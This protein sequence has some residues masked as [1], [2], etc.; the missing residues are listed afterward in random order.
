MQLQAPGRVQAAIRP[1]G[2]RR[3]LVV[4]QAERSVRE[5]SETEDTQKARQNW[6]AFIS[7]DAGRTELS[8]SAAVIDLEPKLAV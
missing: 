1:V 4:S 6:R 8:Q 2:S 3:A 5:R 7:A